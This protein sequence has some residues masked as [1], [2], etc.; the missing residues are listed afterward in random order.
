MGAQVMTDWDTFIST[1]QKQVIEKAREIY[2]ETV[3]Q[4]ALFP[5]NP[6]GM[7][8]RTRTRTREVK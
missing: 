2:S 5:R 6:G 7:T 8:I 4:H 1:V 3:V